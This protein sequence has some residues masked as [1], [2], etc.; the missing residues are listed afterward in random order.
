MKRRLR[1]D[2]H[3]LAG[4]YALNALPEDE[5]RRFEEHLAHCDACVQEVRGLV[6]TTAVLGSAAATTPPEEMRRR[7]LAEVA[8]TRQLTPA[9]EPVFI[10]RSGWRQKA[11]VV[12]LAASVVAA[13]ALGG[14]AY[15]LAQQVEELR[16]D[17]SAVAAV[18]AAPDAEF[19][20]AELD[21]GVSATVVSSG[22]RGELVFSAEGLRPVEGRDYQLWLL[23]GEGDPRSGGLVRL[24]ADGATT[25]L[26][27]TGLGDAEDV[28]VTIE[29]AGGSP[30]PTADPI[31]AMPLNA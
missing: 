18:M 15:R 10:T 6:E 4:P 31:M 20:G 16:R 7:I 12:A 13:L 8:R 2:L 24:R 3:T 21:N 19:N 9:P 29:P 30:A 28:A 22:Q 1:Q 27:A 11:L 14:F 5:L 25:P 26:L 23:D 17:Q